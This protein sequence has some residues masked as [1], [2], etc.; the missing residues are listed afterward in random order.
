[1]NKKLSL[2][3]FTFLFTFLNIQA[4]EIKLPKGRIIDSIPA[5][6][7]TANSFA[8]Y[9]PQ[10]FTTNKE[11]PVL[12]LIDAKG[13]G[14]ASAQLFR[15]IAEEQSYIIAS[16][17]VDVRQDSLQN[18]VKIV[19]SIINRVA[20]MLP[21]DKHQVYTVGLGDGGKVAT[22]L[23]LIYNNISGVLTVDNSWLNTNLLNT[24]NTFMYSAIACNSRFSQFTSQETVSYLDDMDYP[25]EL[26]YYFCE[27]KLEWPVV[28][29]IYNSVSGFTLRAIRNEKRKGNPELI[30]KLYQNEVAYAERLR[31]SR[32]YYP[33]F[34]K[35]KMIEDKYEDL[36]LEVE[37][38]DKIRTIRKNKT[39]KQQRR[40]YRRTA[41]REQEKREEY[42]Y[43]LD[44]DVATANF[45]NTGWWA[46][47]VQELEQKK[48]KA[49]GEKA[50]MA[51]RM[52]GFLDV[53]SKE[54]YDDYVNAPVIPRVKI[55]VSVLRTIFAKKEPEAYFNI[56][57]IAG[58][59]GDH[60]TALLYLEDLL[61]TGFNDMEALYDI[62]GILDLKLSKPYNKIIKQYLGDAKYYEAEL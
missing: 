10:N 12:F 25:T 14:R 47:Q 36:G 4:Q 48:S 52:L 40:E 6:D 3:F 51:S 61:K 33:A 37:L 34:Q 26:N 21:L 31:R 46:Q 50:R 15:R 35:L 30:D 56:I 42:R 16:A 45:E 7:S 54:Y 28:D 44:D 60:E 24:S 22:A 23:S 43:Y 27:E 41:R 38:R 20:G 39:F 11:W 32:N 49:T 55:F 8:L 9:L 17:N 5:T 29:V 1:M 57:K 19:G 13:R 58:H 53:L 18:N 62:E 59:D 2:V